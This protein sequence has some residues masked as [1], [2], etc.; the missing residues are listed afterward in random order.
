MS[1]HPGS[2]TLVTVIK[3]AVSSW[4]HAPEIIGDDDCPIF[5]RWLLFSWGKGDPESPS[6]HQRKVFIHHF[7]PDVPPEPDPHDHPW[8]FVTICLRGGYRDNNYV[9]PARH[10]LTASIDHLRPGSI[11]FR[12]AR[13]AHTTATGTKGAWTLVVTG[14][15]RPES[16]GFW[17]L[18]GTL[19]AGRTWRHY[20][21]YLAE[22][23]NSNWCGS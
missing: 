21:E 12:P 16:W 6:E 7:L 3:K 2:V 18:I 20:R 13:H 4:L 19:P 9:D 14:K 22:H 23:G 5:Q 8:P 15:A 10:A 11:R 17:D 1:S